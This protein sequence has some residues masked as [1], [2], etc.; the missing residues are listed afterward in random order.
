MLFRVFLIGIARRCPAAKLSGKSCVMPYRSMSSLRPSGMRRHSGSSVKQCGRPRERARND[1]AELAGAI[2]KLDDAAIRAKSVSRQRLSA[3]DKE[4]DALPTP[5]PPA[6]S[7]GREVLQQ[8]RATELP[9]IRP[10]S[11]R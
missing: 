10:C 11:R 2:E 3:D 7:R 8:I 4:P 1:A 6:F 5:E 9:P